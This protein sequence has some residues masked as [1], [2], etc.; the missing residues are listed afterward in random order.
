MA[1]VVYPN[2]A[3]LTASM[4]ELFTVWTLLLRGQQSRKLLMKESKIEQVMKVIASK[5]VRQCVL[6]DGSLV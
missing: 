5:L 6:S 2:Q 3:M 1:G 4:I